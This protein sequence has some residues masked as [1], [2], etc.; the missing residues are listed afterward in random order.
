M[1]IK[2][3]IQMLEKVIIDARAS[4]GNLG[5]E[6][7]VNP[8]QVPNNSDAGIDVPTDH[9]DS[10][11]QQGPDSLWSLE[12][13]PFQLGNA[14]NFMYQNTSAPWTT[15]EMGSVNGTETESENSTQMYLLTPSSNP[16][17]DFGVQNCFSPSPVNASISC[18]LSQNQE[19]PVR[20]SIPH[21]GDSVD[22][23]L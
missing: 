13:V 5:T 2:N 16:T 15:P 18:D 14:A 22:G 3:R 23:S 8:D 10:Q 21:S 20:Q 12:Q 17:T 9:L 7:T 4:D 19:L 1:Q 11:A 6:T